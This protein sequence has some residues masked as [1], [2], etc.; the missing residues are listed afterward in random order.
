[1]RPTAEAAGGAGGSGADKP[2][3]GATKPGKD[4]DSVKDKSSALSL[5]QFSLS[6]QN[7]N[8]VLSGTSRGLGTAVAGSV[9]GTALLLGGPVLGT[10]VGYN[11]YGYV[12]GGV[13]FVVGTIG[14]T[15]GGAV[16]A[17]GCIFTGFW[18][19]AIGAI[20]TPSAIIGT[21]A[22]KDWD[23]SAQEWVYNDLAEDARRTLPM[24]DDEFL[25]ALKETGSAAAIFNPH[26]GDAPIAGNKAR[27][28]KKNVQDRELYDVL[29][30]E[31]EATVAEIKKQYY[32]KA[33]ANHPDRNRDDPDAHKKF[34]KI[35]EAY[36][37]LSDERLRSAY[38]S[39]GK[40]AVDTQ[41]KM[42]A[43][44]MYAMIFG[45]ENFDAII[46]ELQISTQIK[47]MI[48]N[49][50]L[51][52][53]LLLFKQRK[54]EVQCAV[55][56]ASKLDV[57]V[58]GH[59]SEFLEK[60]R[61]E[62]KDLSESPLGGALLDLIGGLYMDQAKSELSYLDSLLVSARQNGSAF[63][64]FWST[65]VTG[66]Q[67]AI[68]ALE[69]SSLQA[70]AD[71]KQK[72][73]DDKNNVPDEERE[74]RKKAAGPFGGASVGPGPSATPEEKK[75]FRDTTKNVTGHVF[76][77]MWSVT[78]ADVQQTLANV[79]TRV[80][81][82]H[83]ITPESRSKR[84]KALLILGEEYCKCGVPV[85]TGIEDFLSKLGTQTGMFGPEQTPAPSGDGE[86]QNSDA[87]DG[88]TNGGPF[89]G[90]HPRFASE[91]KLM[92]CLSEVESLGIKEMR[93]RIEQ[94]RG[95]AEGCIEKGDIKIRLKSVLCRHLPVE[96]LRKHVAAQSEGVFDVKDASREVLT[97]IILQL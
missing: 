76:L 93:L 38:D 65:I 10:V 60:T 91:A 20:R 34:Q 36:Q 12:G 55:N 46:G 17:V 15:L 45:N 44:A 72:A 28:P 61:A 56:L 64:E 18:Q 31:P 83:S 3:A 11:K 30:V 22:G 39:K 79:C 2:G 33:R 42:D 52:P 6:S 49:S 7:P 78:K 43:G 67:A 27:G 26:A 57:Y 90:I 74:K 51:P 58:N 97:D 71:A 1:M 62:A 14:G 68:S 59:E 89:E 23:D 53:D 86:P 41:N 24:T 5:P 35:G 69:L 9:C 73:E 95:T 25:A 94:L 54:R 85:A 32:I 87:S 37:I 13:G 50:N 77:L 82:D 19:L 48:D 47:G 29:G 75:L 4:K 92:Q 63:L 16:V 66:A 88:S 84:A 80:L 8:N 70:K 81:H 96:A 21:A 40:E